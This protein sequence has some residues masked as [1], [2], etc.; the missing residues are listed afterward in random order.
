MDRLRRAAAILALPFALM[1]PARAH[2]PARP[3]IR[4]E[5]ERGQQIER[6]AVNPGGKYLA[7]AV[8]P[9][10]V[11]VWDVTTGRVAHVLR[12][13]GRYIDA[14][15]FSPDERHF[16]SDESEG[17]SI[18]WDLDTGKQVR[19]APHGMAVRQAAFSPDGSRYLLAAGEVVVASVADGTSQKETERTDQWPA[20]QFWPDGQAVLAAS[21]IANRHSSFVVRP[22]LRLYE[23][24][25]RD[26]SD[27]NA[28]FR[29]T[30]DAFVAISPDGRYLPGLPRSV[31]FACN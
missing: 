15:A 29:D 26:Y 24:R 2:D 4:P 27:L 8:H 16:V 3:E 14:L 21:H 10:L 12:G 22:V 19:A 11:Q 18:L 25:G 1:L 31:F 7:A 28:W 6:L 17:K 23:E 30:G 20:A 13:H 9:N 5:I